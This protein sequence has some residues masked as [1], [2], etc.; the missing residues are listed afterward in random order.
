MDNS[1]Y[2]ALSKL[3]RSS[4][5]TEDFFPAHTHKNK[6]AKFQKFPTKNPPSENQKKF[7]DLISDNAASL[8]QSEIDKEKNNSE[9]MV[10]SV[11]NDPRNLTGGV[12][13]A[14]LASSLTGPTT[15][16]GAFSI[17]PSTEVMDLFDKM[18]DKITVMHQTG[19][20][21]TEF[22]LE[23]AQ[24]ASSRFY[25]SKVVIQEFSTA[26][27][28]FNIQFVASPEAVTLMQAHAGDLMAAFQQGNYAFSI[29]RLDTRIAP[30][31][32]GIFVRKEQVTRD[33][34]EK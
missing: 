34:E 1:T 31:H 21:E 14:P 25:G 6:E 7:L 28:A 5:V 32:R 23:G 4:K 11:Q 9:E 12:P 16:S 19:V 18:V 15:V 33:K 2:T 20:T 22:S 27:K 29:N 3:P 30:A 26:P 13:L 8:L 24:F 10:A 17:D